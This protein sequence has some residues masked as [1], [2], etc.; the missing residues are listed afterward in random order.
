MIQKRSPSEIFR[1]ASLS[2]QTF[3]LPR[4]LLDY[5][6]RRRRRARPATPRRRRSPL[7]GS[8]TAPYDVKVEV[9]SSRARLP[10]NCNELAKATLDCKRQVWMHFAKW[11]EHFCVGR[12]TSGQQQD[13]GRTGTADDRGS[14]SDGAKH[15]E[16]PFD[17]DFQA[18]AYRYLGPHR[19][20]QA[21]D[22]G[23]DICLATVR[24]RSFGLYPF[25]LGHMP[26][27]ASC[28]IF[29]I[30]HSLAGLQQFRNDRHGRCS[31]H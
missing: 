28:S 2:R 26:T 3:S 12:T 21:P 16:R 17:A 1:R 31:G 5:Y 14:V 4:S 13:N 18:G 20:S 29:A 30:M 6:A 24:G 23:G 25:A 10:P 27:C 9:S 19:R 11:M 8:G 7:V 22:A 15:G